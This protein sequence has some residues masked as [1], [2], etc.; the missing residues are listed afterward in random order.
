MKVTHLNTTQN[1]LKF[2]ISKKAA[3]LL[4]KCKDTV[5]ITYQPEADKRS[6]MVKFESGNMTIIALDLESKYKFP[7]YQSIM[8]KEENK[9]LVTIY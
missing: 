4:L 6:A 3:T 9:E 8:A 5:K 2:R 1:G 7:D